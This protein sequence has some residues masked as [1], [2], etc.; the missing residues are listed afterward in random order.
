LSVGIW[1][2]SNTSNTSFI[3]THNR[4]IQK[5]APEC[6]QTHYSMHRTTYFFTTTYPKGYGSQLFTLS[7]SGCNTTRQH[8][9]RVYH[10]ARND[11]LKCYQHQ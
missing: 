10:H 11:S 5:I 6:Y 8:Q 1:H 9:R 3:Q 2:V 4:M 7:I